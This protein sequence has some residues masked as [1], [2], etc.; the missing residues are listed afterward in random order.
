MPSPT[1]ERYCSVD[2]RNPLKLAVDFL[3]MAMLHVK[4]SPSHHHSTLSYRTDLCEW[5]GKIYETLGNFWLSTWNATNLCC[6]V[7]YTR[8]VEKSTW[9]RQK[10]RAIFGIN[11]I[12]FKH[13]AV[14]AFRCF[15]TYL[16]H[17]N[18]LVRHRSRLSLFWTATIHNRRQYLTNSLH[19][20]YLSDHVQALRQS[21]HQYRRH[22]LLTV[23]IPR[24]C[25][26]DHLQLDSLCLWC[27]CQLCH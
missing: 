14:H 3:S 1:S 18:Y 16:C 21:C 7:Y 23:Q 6:I 2:Y 20:E 10:C 15:G 22:V 26:V 17:S 8:N 25:K 24:D 19:Y 9:Q 27:E 4:Y 11:C 13:S 12:D 5:N